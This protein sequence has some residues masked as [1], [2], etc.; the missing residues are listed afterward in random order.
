MSSNSKEFRTIIKIFLETIGIKN[1]DDEIT[2]VKAAAI[3]AGRILDPGSSSLLHA[4]SL[5]S[6]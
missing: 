5:I 2:L 3:Y 6:A 1:Q 4:L